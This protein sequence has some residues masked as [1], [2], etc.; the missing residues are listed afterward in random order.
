MD[1]KA[2]YKLSYG[3]FLLGASADGRDNACITN[4][5][6]QVAS[7]PTRIAIAVINTNFTCDLVKKA[8]RFAITLLDD[9]VSFDTIKFFGMQS[10]RN[11]DKFEY[12]TPSKDAWGMPYID[13]SRLIWAATPFSS[14][15]WRTRRS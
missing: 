7:N 14:R 1:N 11:V 13:W 12:L 2:F 5:C 3:V 4:T 6:I 9:T 8:G 10:G 15:R